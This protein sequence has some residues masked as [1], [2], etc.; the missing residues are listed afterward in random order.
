MRLLDQIKR[1]IRILFDKPGRGTGTIEDSP[2]MKLE[3][4]LRRGVRGD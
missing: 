2:E 3:S 4:E 1:F